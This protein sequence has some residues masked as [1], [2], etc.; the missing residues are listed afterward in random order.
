MTRSRNQIPR[1]FVVAM[2]GTMVVVVSA[3]AQHLQQGR[4]A[5][6]DDPVAKRMIEMERDWAEDGCKQKGPKNRFSLTI[7]KVRL[8]EASDT[9]KLRHSSTIRP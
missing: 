2:L 9:T 7:F 6:K 8:R 4:W 5:S 1:K 3:P